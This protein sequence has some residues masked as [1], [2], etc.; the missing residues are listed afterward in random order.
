[1]M[2]KAADYTIYWG[3][4]FTRLGILY[5]F[6]LVSMIYVDTTRCKIESSLGFYCS[7]IGYNK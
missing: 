6:R 1:M 5:K 4:H 2:S 3:N 7:L